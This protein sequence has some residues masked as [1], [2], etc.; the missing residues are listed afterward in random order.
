MKRNSL[1]NLPTP[2]TSLVNVESAKQRPVVKIAFLD[3]GQADTIIVSCSDTHEAIIVDCVN[4]DAV[5][6]YL[7]QEQIIYLRGVIVTHLHADHYAGV[8][9]LL[10][11]YG[12]VPN[13]QEG[14]RLAL[15][16]FPNL[17]SPH[18][19]SLDRDGHSASYEQPSVGAKRLAPSSLAKLALWSKQNL[20][21]CVEIKEDGQRTHPPFVGTL[22]Q[23]IQLLHPH[24][25]NYSELKSIGLNNTST[26]LRVKGSNSSALLTGDIEPDGWQYLQE[27]H[28]GLQ[29]DVLKF[30]HHGGAWDE[31][32]TNIL[33]DHLQPSVV[34]I[35]VGTDN[36]YGHPSSGVF[37]ALHKRCD[38]RLLCTEATEQ[39]QHLVQSERSSVIH[40]LELQSKKSNNEFIPMKK[41]SCPCAGTVII[42]LGDKANVLQP[43]IRFHHETIIK[44]HFKRHKCNL[45][46]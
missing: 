5:M 37:T 43:E 35:S 34:V 21:S 1:E 18:K 36:S 19:L 2:S 7:E 33:L 38:I 4:A 15:N 16:E 24:H 40:Q 13:I 8:A 41:Q 12:L 10:N 9:D 44:P 45:N 17:R 25:V 39:C 31:V 20:S 26:V 23:N 42:E 46:E 22:A 3:V 30:P 14:G 11:N 32:D 27:N 28:L 29:C 6:D